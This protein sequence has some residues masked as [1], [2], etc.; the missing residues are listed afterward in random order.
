[1]VAKTI[2]ALSLPLHFVSVG[3]FKPFKE[4]IYFVDLFIK[5]R[6]YVTLSKNKIC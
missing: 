5:Q 6:K 3:D 4:G 2:L 1:M